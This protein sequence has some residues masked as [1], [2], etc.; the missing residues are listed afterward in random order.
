MLSQV[1]AYSSGFPKSRISVSGE[2]L[3]WGSFRFLSGTL[4][5]GCLSGAWSKI[6]G[7]CGAFSR[8]M[9]R[10]VLRPHLP[11]IPPQLH[12]RNTRTAHAF[13]QKPPGKTPIHHKK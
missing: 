13:S 4:P 5:Q 2:E 10:G 9:Q 7:I 12:H 1:Y 3:K 11:R 8:L 6:T